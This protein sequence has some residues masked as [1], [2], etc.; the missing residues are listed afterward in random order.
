MISEVLQSTA[1]GLI[2]SSS[3]FY[4]LKPGH[5]G[6]LAQTTSGTWDKDRSC[7]SGSERAW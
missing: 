7:P 2:F 1:R 5:P 4:F 3:F 6:Y